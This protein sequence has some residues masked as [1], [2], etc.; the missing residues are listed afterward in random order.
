M[1]LH[2]QSSQE[3]LCLQMRRNQNSS[4]FSFSFFLFLL[5]RGG[6]G[7]TPGMVQL[8]GAKEVKQFKTLSPAIVPIYFC[9][10]NCRNKAIHIYA[11]LL[12]NQKQPNREM[13][14]SFPFL[15]SFLPFCY[16]FTLETQTTK[17]NEENEIYQIRIQTFVSLGEVP[18]PLREVIAVAHNRAVTLSFPVICTP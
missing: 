14:F 5:G 2:S 17:K 3:Q 9:T 18:C 13:T 7:V 6:T 4:L 16:T 11:I 15:D 12:H 1:F 10:K 8:L